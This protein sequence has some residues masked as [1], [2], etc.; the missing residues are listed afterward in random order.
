MTVSVGCIL[1]N[2]E[3]GGL[4]DGYYDFEPLKAELAGSPRVPALVKL[5]EGKYWAER[6]G[7]G[8]LLAAK[9][10]SDQF[11]VPYIGLLGYRER[12]PMPPAIFYNPLVLTH[13]PP[14]HGNGSHHDFHDQRNLAHFRVNGV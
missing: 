2:Y 12:G 8:L 1:F 7:Q 13:V 3:S 10:I 9:A 5:C 11:G 6:G 4:K 14:W